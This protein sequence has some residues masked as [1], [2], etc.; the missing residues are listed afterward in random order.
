MNLG[1]NI[2][3]NSAA[4]LNSNADIDFGNFTV[5]GT[6]SFTTS[7]GSTLIIGSADGL[8][9]SGATGNVQVSGTR[10]FNA[11]SIY[12]Y[13]GSAAQ[14]TGNGLPSTIGELVIDNAANVS[15]SSDVNVTSLITFNAGRLNLSSSRLS[16][17]S[18]IHI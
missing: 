16:Y 12:Y 17:L 6:G 18:L 1:N 8:S 15:L 14:V 13:N 5:S 4:I 11:G 9:V 7:S 2:T 3:V 10:T